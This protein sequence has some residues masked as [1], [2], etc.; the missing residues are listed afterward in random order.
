MPSKTEH[1]IPVLL[2]PEDKEEYDMA[3]QI[4]DRFQFQGRHTIENVDR[5]IA[6]LFEEKGFFALLTAARRCCILPEMVLRK[7]L[8]TIINGLDL[9]AYGGQ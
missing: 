2:T 4:H 5:I 7:A 8:F 3:I 6:E 9:G 1:D